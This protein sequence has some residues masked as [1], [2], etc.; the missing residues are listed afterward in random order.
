[1]KNWLK[2][3]G[4]GVTASLKGSFSFNRDKGFF[5]LHFPKN[6]RGSGVTASLHSAKVRFTFLPGIEIRVFFLSIF[7]KSQKSQKKGLKGA[8]SG[9]TA[10]L[11]SAFSFNRDKGLFFSPFSQK[12]KK[13]GL[14]GAR[15]GRNG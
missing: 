14:K 9:V 4:S 10:S 3:R 5:S 15:L 6:G 13:N 11:H 2:G 7:P 1:M 12:V 8:G